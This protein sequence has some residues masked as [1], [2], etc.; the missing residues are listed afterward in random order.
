MEHSQATMRLV[1]SSL[2]SLCICLSVGDAAA[3]ACT[4]ELKA[5]PVLPA[6]TEALA[7]GL[8][9]CGLIGAP[10]VDDPSLVGE[11]TF[12]D[13]MWRRHERASECIWIPQ[14]RITLRSAAGIV[15]DDYQTIP[16]IDDP[17]VSDDVAGEVVIRVPDGDDDGTDPDPD[18]SELR[19]L[20]QDCDLAWGEQEKGLLALSIGNFIGRGDDGLKFGVGVAGVALNYD[21]I[22]G[23]KTLESPAFAVNDPTVVSDPD[24]EKVLAHEVGHKLGICHPDQTC[25]TAAEAANTL[26]DGPGPIVLTE[27]QCEAA[28]T[29]LDGNTQL[30]PP[31]GSGEV[32]GLIDGR[33]DPD[34]A[35]I[36]DLMDIRKL[37]AV[38]DTEKG[39]G[40]T[41]ALRM[42]G[43]LGANQVRFVVGLDVDN[44]ESTGAPLSPLVPGSELQGV[45]VAFLVQANENGTGNVQVREAVAG[46]LQIINVPG[47]TAQAFTAEVVET[48]PDALPPKPL[49]SDM[50]FSATRAALETLGMDTGAGR[51]FPNGLAIQAASLVTLGDGETFVDVGP[52]AKAV[53]GFPDPDFPS[54]EVSGPVCAGD[55]IDISVE[56]LADGRE[57]MVY[58]GEEKIEPGVVTDTEGNVAFS[59]TVPEDAIAGPTLLTVG[60]KDPTN[61]VTADTIIDL[62]PDD[63]GDNGGGRRPVYAAKVVCGTEETSSSSDLARGRYTTTVNVYNPGRRPVQLRKQLALAVP[64]GGERPG[65]VFTL[66][67]REVLPPGRAMAVQCRELLTVSKTQPGNYLDGFVAIRANGPLKVTAV[68]SALSVDGQ[69]GPV[70]DV[71][72]VAPSTR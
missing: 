72:D 30:D 64:P 44:D 1:G 60:V 6:D 50:I 48:G 29:T 10:A 35:D 66:A 70:L 57:V 37:V 53:L 11:D 40:M 36:P 42:Q 45:D 12:K 56:G 65:R 38:D 46:N 26:M 21:D 47:I 22:S 67:E 43:P 69:S 2:L 16:D 59:V 15:K 58:L 51:L 17:L 27:G 3:Q 62:C 24:T 71:E 19:E 32:L 34:E 13:M 5:D 7:V 9:W 25:S 61:A 4:P 8:R 14:C 23:D 55:P 52:D 63:D 33:G 68:Y 39:E 18:Y 49:A 20:W 31:A 41:L 54:I 28:R